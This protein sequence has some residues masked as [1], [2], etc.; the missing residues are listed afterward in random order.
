MRE[1]RRP[2]LRFKTNDIEEVGHEMSGDEDYE[3]FYDLGVYAVKQS[4]T[5]IAKSIALLVS[6]RSLDLCKESMLT[7]C[8][9]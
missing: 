7:M 8:G 3:E 1:K 4:K 5:M 6:S 2:Y 9:V